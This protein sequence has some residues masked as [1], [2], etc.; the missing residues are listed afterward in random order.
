M[1]TT[2]QRAKVILSKFDPVSVDYVRKF[3]EEVDNLTVL[4]YDPKS[5]DFIEVDAQEDIE[6][7]EYVYIQD[8]IC[9]DLI[10]GC[11]EFETIYEALCRLE[12]EDKK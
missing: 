8:G 11:G 12:E 9:E 3:K 7:I 4:E 1:T 2:K 5:D 6:S 10:E